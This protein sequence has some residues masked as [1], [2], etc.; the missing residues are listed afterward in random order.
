M[1]DNYDYDL[2]DDY[3]NGQLSSEQKTTFEQKM[4]QNEGL[5]AEVSFEKD[6]LTGIQVVGKEELSNT[7]NSIGEELSLEEMDIPI[8]GDFS[9]EEMTKGIEQVGKAELK[10]E[11]QDL[12][13][14]LDQSGFFDEVFD[15]VQ[16]ETTSTE[17][18]PETAKVKQLWPMRRVLSIAAGVALLIFGT[19]LAF[20]QNDG[21][22]IDQHFQPYANVVSPILDDQ[23]EELG[24]AT[25]EVVERLKTLQKGM[26]AYES[27]N[28]AETISNLANQ[29]LTILAS[30]DRQL[31]TFYLAIS[32][33]GNK[34]ITAATPLLTSLANNANF[35]QQADA[36]WY[37]LLAY[38]EAGDQQNADA[39]KLKLQTHPKYGKMVEAL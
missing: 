33:L 24:L 38:L 14:E 29:D 13:A 23:I 31:I 2:I 3:L 17:T 8:Y 36:Q 27:G 22:P 9:D 6:L 37:L 39:L 16:T 35:T 32:Y 28:Y 5:A 18:A 12:Q 11:I 4:Q 30:S 21:D 7:I 34:D 19:W 10:N 1:N 15:K 20:F 25:G 26:K